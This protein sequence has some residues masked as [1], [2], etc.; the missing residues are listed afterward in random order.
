MPSKGRGRAP[1]SKKS[2]GKSAKSA[3]SSKASKAGHKTSKSGKA[4]RSSKTSKSGSRSASAARGTGR[5]R[6]IEPGCTYLITRKT[7]DD[8]FWLTPS[9]L[10][11]AVLLYLLI[12]KA[13][14]H[15][16]LIHGF[17]FLSTH[18]HLLATDPKGKL[19]AFMNEYVSETGKALKIV[20]KSTRR[21]WSG[22]RYSATKLLDLDAAER[23]LA[24]ALLNPTGAELTDPA[25]WPGLTSARFRF[26]ETISAAR[27]DI[28]F[29][30]K[31]CLLASMVLAPLSQAFPA[32]IESDSAPGAAQGAT[33]PGVDASES[34][35]RDLV[36]EGRAAI[37]RRLAKEGRRLAG[38][39]RVLRTPWTRRATHPIGEL[40]P[41]FATRDAELLEAAI[42][43]MR[44]FEEEHDAAK[45]RYM[46]GHHRTLFP[47]GTYGYRVVLGVRVAKKRRRAA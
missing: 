24:Y 15:G 47:S 19:P 9:A 40:H 22:R 28:Y 25:V 23:K 12:L 18:F 20:R 17:V 13:T 36:E 14:K 3:R 26:G 2:S 7:N 16:M 32:A 30:K 35:I 1:A 37:H 44:Q 46:A 33:V 42:E 29:D 31:R 39:A 4:S 27:P 38:V 21:V 41:L 8:L 43:E 45:Q 5:H 11:N 6:R 34:R 10:V